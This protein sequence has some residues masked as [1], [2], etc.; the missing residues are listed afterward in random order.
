MT[1]ETLSS[2]DG[3]LPE[4][5]QRRGGQIE[6]E[7]TEAV[8]H[9][10]EVLAAGVGTT[11][12]SDQQ[13][14]QSRGKDGPPKFETTEHQSGSVRCMERVDSGRKLRETTISSVQSEGDGEILRHALA[15]TESKRWNDDVTTADALR[16]R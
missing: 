6:Q 11:R 2:D 12:G 16:I 8:E 15:A 5:I 4:R 7:G 3:E 14:D 13:D 1:D 10:S 9:P